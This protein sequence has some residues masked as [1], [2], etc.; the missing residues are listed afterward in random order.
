MYETLYRMAKEAEFDAVISAF[1]TELDGHKVITTY[2]FPV[3]TRLTREYIE[4]EIMTY[5]LQ[6]DQMNTVWNK[7]YKRKLLV[8][9]DVQFPEKMALGED[10]VFNI[11]FF[12]HAFLVIST[13]YRGYHYREVEGSATR[14]IGKKD[15]FRR[16]LD[17]Y[18]EHLPET[19]LINLDAQSIK[20]LKSIKLMKSVMAICHVYL[21]ASHQLN[22]LD[23]LQ[24]VTRMIHHPIVSEALPHYHKKKYTSLGR[25]EKL[26]TYF[27]RRK[28]IL[29]LYLCTT[30]SRLRSKSM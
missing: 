17:V 28:S 10:G 12:A 13:N 20:Q 14:D 7:L 25:Y 11:R 1:E 3:D 29:G 16:A 19:D 30:Y 15:Y 22:F 26:I 6:S 18:S 27:I 2:P 24:Y 9:H 21:N 8:E 23:R 4:Q 5:L